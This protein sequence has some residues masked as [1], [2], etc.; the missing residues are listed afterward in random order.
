[1]TEL[2]GTRKKPGRKK[3]LKV[4]RFDKDVAR[5]IQDGV[6]RIEDLTIRLGVDPLAAQSRLALLVEKKL[7][8]FDADSGAYRLGVEG[9]NK[10]APRMKA[11]K[12]AKP[13]IPGKIVSEKEVPPMSVPNVQVFAPEK[14]LST[15]PVAEK[16]LD[17]L[18]VLDASRKA[19]DEKSLIR[20]P[21]PVERIDL[22]A[23]LEK[24]RGN[25]SLAGGRPSF[26]AGELCELCR[27]PFKISVRE[28]KL[29]K[30]AHCVCGSAYHQDCYQSLVD[31]GAGCVRCGRK[32]SAVLD[33][34]SQEALK[35]VKD[36]F[37]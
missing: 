15:L 33:R 12:T 11:V 14:T 37:E 34:T 23:L 8:V 36:A 27:A 25:S 30:F 20:K 19:L 4:S 10:F 1:M 28:P 16:A 32:L 7:L 35:F 24:G 2:T 13:A 29:A 17:V 26:K 9:Y 21:A 31:G 22:G 5:L 6:L 3:T 18:A